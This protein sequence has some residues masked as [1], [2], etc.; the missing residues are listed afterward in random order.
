MAS[1]SAQEGRRRLEN[2][3]LVLPLF[4][5]LL[6]LPP[7]LWVFGAPV[8]LFGLPVELIYVFGVCGLLIAGTALMARRLDEGE[9]R[10]RDTETP[11]QEEREA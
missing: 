3:A 1:Q 7:V 11:P 5:L 4:G 8:R 6:L 9:R 10:G 2:L